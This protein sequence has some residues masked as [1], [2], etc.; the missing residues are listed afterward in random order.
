MNIFELGRL[1]DAHPASLRIDA[2]RTYDSSMAISLEVEGQA[3]LMV[4]LPLCRRFAG[5]T[6]GRIERISLERGYP[7]W[8]LVGE[9][10]RVTFLEQPSGR[11]PPPVKAF[12]G[13]PIAAKDAKAFDEEAMTRNPLQPEDLD[14]YG[15]RKPH[16]E[17]SLAA[18]FAAAPLTLTV[19]SYGSD[20]SALKPREMYTCI[21]RGRTLEFTALMLQDV[22]FF[23]GDLR[24]KPDALALQ[25][26][27]GGYEIVGAET[28]ICFRSFSLGKGLP[29]VPSR[30][31]GIR[32]PA[33]LTDDELVRRLTLGAPLDDLGLP[34]FEGR[35]DLRGVALDDLVVGLNGPGSWTGIDFS[36]A[37]FTEL[38]VRNLIVDNCLFDKARLDSMRMWGSQVSR[39]PASVRQPWERPAS[40]ASTRSR[41]SI[42]PGPIWATAAGSLR[43]STGAN[44]T[45]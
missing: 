37:T 2:Y 28:R 34:L 13:A 10:T 4:N 19:L 44:S 35:I 29:V 6:E 26:V 12:D 43:R 24:G 16:D 5:A 9:T 7:G 15:V 1:L 23:S 20:W 30:P 42:S 33:P 22:T 41:T 40:W 25:R 8:M 45:G 32:T 21:R 27:E 36:G 39:G 17:V 18:Y 38:M 14:S 31:R 11:R 3:S